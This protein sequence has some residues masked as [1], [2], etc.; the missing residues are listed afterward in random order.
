M[1][2]A[3]Q[4]WM[5]R[6]DKQVRCFDWRRIRDLFL[7]LSAVFQ[8]EQTAELW[9]VAL[10]LAQVASDRCSSPVLYHSQQMHCALHRCTVGVVATV[11]GYRQACSADYYET[12]TQWRQTSSF[13]RTGCIRAH[14]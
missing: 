6:C 2:Y 5:F 3:K 14:I 1:R 13:G 12:Y 9:L 11:S 4:R 7:D 8:E 10:Q